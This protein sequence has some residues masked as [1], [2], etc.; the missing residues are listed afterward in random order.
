MI[1]QQ[2]LTF[3]PISSQENWLKKKS[4]I[5]IKLPFYMP[6]PNIQTNK[7]TQIQKPLQGKNTAKK[8]ILITETFKSSNPWQ[9]KAK[10]EPETIM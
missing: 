3:F 7:K 2:N 8:V 4:F 9:N 5:L 6:F 10:K 1:I